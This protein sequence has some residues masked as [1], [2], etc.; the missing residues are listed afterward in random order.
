MSNTNKDDAWEKIKC[1]L[2]QH[3]NSHSGVA[4]AVA[5][6]FG[7]L[8]LKLKP[9]QPNLPPGSFGLPIISEL[10]GWVRALESGT[11][12]KWIEERV[13][14]HGPIFKTSFMGNRTVVVTGLVANKFVFTT[15]D[16]MLRS[17]QPVPIVYISGEQSIFEVHGARHKLVRGA[18]AGFL[19]PESL[20][21]SVPLMSSLI[22]RYLTKV[23][24]TDRL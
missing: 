6:L 5:V 10:I 19:R 23:W 14:R 15:G 16:D 2:F 21:R 18:I 4:V 13:A 3:P 9:S 20:Q 11:A 12:Y 22:K 24:T 7:W 1:H 8:Y 17:H